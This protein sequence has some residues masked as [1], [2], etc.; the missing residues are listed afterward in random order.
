M[1]DQ[2]GVING[3]VKAIDNQG[4]LQVE[5]QSMPGAPCSAWAPV[6]APLAGKGRGAFFMPEIGDEVLVAFLYG[7]FDQ[8]YVVGALGMDRTCRLRRIRRPARSGR[9]PGTSFSSTT[10][11]ASTRSRSIR[12]AGMRSSS[13]TRWP[14]SSSASRRKEG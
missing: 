6:A 14:G 8:P 3:I 4:R 1:R 11:T 9:S 12:A 10:A 5:F 13:T 2:P 7:K